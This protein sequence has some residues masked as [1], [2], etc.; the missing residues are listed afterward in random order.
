MTVT[1]SVE[2]E[3][4]PAPEIL[5]PAPG[6][7]RL[8]E[9]ARILDLDERSALAVADG[10]PDFPQR[11]LVRVGATNRWV[12]FFDAALVR[13]WLKEF[14]RMGKRFYFGAVSIRPWAPPAARFGGGVLRPEHAAQLR[15]RGK[16]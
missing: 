8:A 12:P 3:E 9:V 11:T 10:A 14:D 13:G 7:V 15:S 2:A 4:R 16:R 6:F 1:L 5:P